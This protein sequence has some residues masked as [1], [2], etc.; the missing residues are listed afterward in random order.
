[1]QALARAYGHNP[2]RVARGQFPATADV[3]TSFFAS[4]PKGS[5]SFVFVQRDSRLPGH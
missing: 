3:G 4:D 2:E 5:L 1:M